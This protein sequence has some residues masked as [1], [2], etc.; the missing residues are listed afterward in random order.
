MTLVEDC[1]SIWRTKKDA[2]VVLRIMLRM[3]AEGVSIFLDSLCDKDALFFAKLYFK[4]IK[5]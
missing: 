1:L 5:F 3:N 4:N 2:D